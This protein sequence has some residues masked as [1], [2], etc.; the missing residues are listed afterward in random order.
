MSLT[1]ADFFSH[2]FLKTSGAPYAACLVYHYE[3]G[4]TTTR[5]AWSDE[6]ATSAVADPFVADASG[7]AVFYGKGNYRILVKASV[8]DGNATL[9][10]WDPL[11][12][13]H[14]PAGLP[15]ETR[16]LSYPSATAGNRG[17]IA[18]KISAGGDT[19]EIGINLDASGFSAFQL[20]GTALA[21]T[22]QWA[23]GAD[24]ASAS[25][26]TLGSDG[27]TFDVTGAVTITSISA[28]S[29]GTL[30]LLQFDGSLT[31]THN[32][33][34]LILP[35]AANIQTVAGD[36]AL[37]QSEGTGN[38]RVAIYQRKSGLALIQP[39]QKYLYG[40]TYANGSDATNDLD[41]A[42]GGCMDVTGAQW[43]ATAALTKQSDATFVVGTAQGMLD[44]GAVGN[45]DYY[46]FA[47]YRD[48]TQVSDYLCSLSATAPT[49]PAGYTHKRLIGWFKRVGGTIVA[50]DTYETE[51]GGLELTWDVPTLDVN[52]AST[53]TTSRRTDAVKVP[54][55]FATTAH[56]NVVMTDASNTFN[57]WVYCPDQADTAPSM[58]ASPLSNA[59]SYLSGAAGSP[60]QLRIR[61]SA[62]GTIA[63][64]ASLATVDLYAVAT[65][66]FAWAR[67][68]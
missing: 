9:Y 11:K 19:T 17:L 1:G 14:Q 37:L 65:V 52:L 7:R 47:I 6:A 66:G 42:A 2:V 21:V 36:M 55:N 30:I 62:T 27:N 22:Q 25:T 29:A 10:D 34:S 54:L 20:Q 59:G 53:L 39:Q 67:R 45:S 43:F 18:Q 48:D 63:A 58:T 50:F 57:V 16:A 28:K 26:L 24:I 61:T 13:E 3:P 23:K 56:L 15:A 41:I 35:S 51:G 12:L 46:L 5:T 44:T 68:N 49:M 32:A 33:T 60:S 8:A 40:H 31:L 38:W 64:R 4:T